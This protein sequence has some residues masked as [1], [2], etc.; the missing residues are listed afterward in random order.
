[1]TDH[2]RPQLAA[3]FWGERYSETHVLSDV[4]APPYDVISPVERETLSRKHEH[5]IVH[6]VL[7]EGEGD[8]YARAAAL[9]AEW[10]NAGV[11]ERDKSPSVYV[12]RQSFAT[13]MGRQ[14][15]RTGVIVGL[16]AESFSEGRVR[17]HERTH[18]GPKE[19]RLSLLRAT[20]AMFEAIFVLARDEGGE[21][22]ARLEAEAARRPTARAELHGVSLA[23][24]RV[25]AKR[26]RTLADVASSGPVY[27]ADGHHRFETAVAFRAELPEAERIPA[28][29]VPVGDPGLVVLATHRRV[30]GKPV[31]PEWLIEQL[32]DRF[33][34]RELR[35]SANYVEELSELAG[36]GTSA[37]VVFPPGR[38]FAFLLKG[39]AGLGDVRFSNEPAVASLDVARIDEIIVRRV[40]EAAGSGA[41]VDYSADPHAVIDAVRAGDAAAGILLNPATVE[42]VLTVADEGGVMP[43]KSTYFMPKVPSG[44]VVAGY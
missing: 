23:L 14:C 9:L 26:A 15:E 3:P 35:P 8:R 41:T 33:Q 13:P 44:L 4:I 29:V 6:L 10:R 27:V 25:P 17:P 34:V 1:M 21:L 20:R 39:G 28:L 40:Q 24:W 30:R 37:L 36:R 32:R 2:T 31:D 11:F 19:D 18:Q 22:A 42:D 7:P 5:N 38:G 43:P 16:L 12:L